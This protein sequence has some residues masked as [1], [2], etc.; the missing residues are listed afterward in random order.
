VT[1]WLGFGGEGTWNWVVEGKSGSSERA[2]SGEEDERRRVEEGAVME[3]ERRE[4]DMTS[5]LNRSENSW[6]VQWWVCTEVTT[7]L[8]NWKRKALS[9]KDNGV[10]IM[11][12]KKRNERGKKSLEQGREGGL[13][14]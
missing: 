4:D 7:M 1:G 11:A 9:I 12:V 5:Y 13:W 6:R 10:V 8:R 3:E 14:G 2:S